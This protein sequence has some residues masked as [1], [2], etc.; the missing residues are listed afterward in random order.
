MHRSWR[1]LLTMALALAITWIPAEAAAQAEFSPFVGFLFGANIDPEDPSG[2][3]IPRQ[4][5]DS[6]TWGARGAY[7]FERAPVIGLEGSFTQSPF[8][9]FQIQD[10]ELDNRAT[11]VDLNLVLQTTGSRAQF[12]GT[13]GLGLTRFRLGASEGGQTHTKLGVN[14]GVGVKV[15]MWEQPAGVWGLRADVRDHYLRMEADDSMRAGFRDQ[16]ALPANSF[17]SI[18]NVVTT[19]AAYF[20]F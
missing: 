19:V 12:Y 18:H 15:P 20:R 9:N 10:L 6:F 13:A 11:Y 7:F 17:S 4:F 14:F 16:L 2:S 1:F 5:D 8:A 3:G